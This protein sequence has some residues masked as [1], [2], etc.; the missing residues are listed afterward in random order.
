MNMKTSNA[1]PSPARAA[2]ARQAG[3]TLLEI[4]IVLAIIALVMGVL[5]GPKLMDMFSDAK[6]KTAGIVVNKFATEA[7][8]R[9][10]LAN[11][12][13]QC[14][15]DISEL[16]KYGGGDDGAVDPWGNKLTL[17]CGEAAPEGAP[18]RVVVISSGEDGQQGTDDDIKSWNPRTDEKK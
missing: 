1:K 10:S 12:G 4:L 5:F 2:L 18:S 16:A 9:W 17:L 15:E 8:T 14:P 3:M 13:K 7:Y 6:K 11:T